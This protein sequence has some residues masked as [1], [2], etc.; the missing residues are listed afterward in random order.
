M[1]DFREK[2]TKVKRSEYHIDINTHS[3]FLT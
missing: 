1:H 2:K 3:C